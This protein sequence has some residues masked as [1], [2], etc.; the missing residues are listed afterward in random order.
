MRYAVGKPNSLMLEFARQ[1]LQ[2]PAEGLGPFGAG[3]VAVRRKK[4]IIGDRLDTDIRAGVEAGIDTLLVLSGVSQLAD[5]REFGF[6]PTMILEG[7]DEI[8]FKMGQWM[9]EESRHDT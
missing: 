2:Q 5:V 7:L 8:S 6:R 3:G 4:L 1:K 9:R